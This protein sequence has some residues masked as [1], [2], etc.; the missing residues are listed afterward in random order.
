MTRDQLRDYIT[1]TPPIAIT[2]PA[3]ERYLAA[4]RTALRA[5]HLAR[6]DGLVPCVLGTTAWHQLLILTEAGRLAAGMEP[7]RPA[8]K[9]RTLFD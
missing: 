7:I 2:R 8:V 1:P 5:G 9:A 4:L 6:A 3:D